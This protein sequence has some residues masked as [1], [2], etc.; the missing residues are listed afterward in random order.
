MLTVAALLVTG[1]LVYLPWPLALFVLLAGT[2][3]AFW[4]IGKP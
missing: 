2:A 1:A 4:I 3:F